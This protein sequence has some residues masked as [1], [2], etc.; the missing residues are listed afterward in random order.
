ML[1]TLVFKCALCDLV[2]C[3]SNSEDAST[4]EIIFVLCVCV[5]RTGDR[6]RR[7]ETG[8]VSRAATMARTL[9]PCSS[10][11]TDFTLCSVSSSSFIIIMSTRWPRARVIPRRRRSPRMGC[12]AS[13]P[14]SP[15]HARASSRRGDGGATAA[16]VR[17]RYGALRVKQ[18]GAL[19]AL[20]AAETS[21]GSRTRCERLCQALLSI[22]VERAVDVFERSMGEC[23]AS[24]STRAPEPAVAD[25]VAE[26][27]SDEYAR[28]RDVG[29][30]VVRSQS[31][32]VVL[33]A[34]GQGTR[35]G[36]ANP[37]GM[38]DIG[39]PSAKSLFALQGERLAKLGALAGAPPPVWY[40]MTS[41][42]THDMTTRYFKRH[43]YFG[44]N[45]KDVKFFKQGTLPCFT[46]A[47]EI[48]LKSFDEVSEAPDGNGG[49]YA[50]LAREG[51]IDDM[52]ARGIEHVYAYCVDNALVQVG[53]P[54]FVGCCVERRCDAGAKVI[55]KAYPTEPVGVFATR[56][57][58]ETGKKEYHVV[59]YSEIPESLATAKDKRTGELKFN[60][61][62]IALHYYSFEFLAKCC[63]DLK[64]PHHIARK[65]I[66]FLD[67]ATG[68][69]VT[70][71]QPN[72]IK[73]EAFI[74]DVYKYANS[75]CVVQGHRARDF[76]P[77]KNAEGTGKDSPD[78]ARELITTLHA[79]WITD[80]GGVIE[81]VPEGV[82]PACEI[83]ASASY[84]GENI[85]PGVRVP[86][87][88]YVQTFAK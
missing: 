56:I 36:S 13:K 64:L 5:W 81:N 50:A 32:A 66:P 60:A 15:S 75:V 47:G 40:V 10:T 69:T 37:K 41:P 3:Q 18:D 27:G 86:H 85:P 77:V 49:I 20:D 65:K 31:L 19:A 30:D 42:F 88:S 61:A 68:E 35:L 76:A 33:L 57:N 11:V 78:T 22:D 8:E 17:A 63:L 2:S 9:N 14:S 1:F 46:E 28:W 51:I 26:P 73:L 55:T 53:D 23:A 71:E 4:W 67:V 21:P 84:A 62:N 83:A 79:Q 82:P 6:V 70:P 12:A 34:G 39:L 24:A 48:I 80:A 54:A 45:A 87:A 74:F 16:A 43:K 52:R 7:K 29:L 44:L 59:E 38:Y 58:S 72:G 25:Y